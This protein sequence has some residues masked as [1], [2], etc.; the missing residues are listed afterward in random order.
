LLTHPCVDCG[1]SDPVVLEF[2]HVIGEKKHN[3]AYLVRSGRNWRSITKEIQK[4]EVRCANCHRR[5]TAR[6]DGNW[7]KLIWGLE[8]NAPT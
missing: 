5:A 6:R 3:I 8:E 4:C 2:D 7:K 1:E